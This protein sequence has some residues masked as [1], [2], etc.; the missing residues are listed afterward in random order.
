MILMSNFT[1]IALECWK[2]YQASEVQKKETFPYYELKDS[3]TYAESE[4]KEFDDIAYGYMSKAAIP[5]L[6]CYAVYSVIY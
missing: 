3:K 6:G 4:T 2:I 1:S 5:I